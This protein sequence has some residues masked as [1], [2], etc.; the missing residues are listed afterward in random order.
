MIALEPILLRP[1]ASGADTPYI[2][3]VRVS[4]GEAVAHGEA[5]L[6]DPDV[7]ATA[8]DFLADAVAHTDPADFGLTWQRLMAL[9]DEYTPDPLGDYLAVLG[10]VDVA[11]WDLAGRKLG[12]P[13][14]RLAGG[15]R[16]PRLDCTAGGLRVGQ[17]DLPKAAEALCKQ[18]GAIEFTLSRDPAQDVPAIHRVRRAVGELAPLMADAGP[19]YADLAAARKVGEALAQVEAFWYENPLPHGSWEGYAELRRELGTGLA[20]GRFVTTLAEAERLLQAEAVDLFVADVRRCGGLSAAQRL[21]DMARRHGVRMTFHCGASPLAQAAAAHLAAAHWH[22]GP[23]QIVPPPP[24]VS[25]LFPAAPHFEGG[26]LCVPEE[27]GLGCRLDEPAARQV[28]VE[29]PDEHA[30]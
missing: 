1:S 15:R 22:V 24:S 30:T 20:G 26:F 19:G 4:D 7:F 5:C 28:Q 3:L 13:C 25:R 12:V 16:A 17:D 23:L 2:T 18:F 21:A 27:P 9:L 11:L 14:H 10:A 6:A 29:P 8:V